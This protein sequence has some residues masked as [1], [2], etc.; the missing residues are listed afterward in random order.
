MGLLAARPTSWV[1]GDDHL[2]GRVDEHAVTVAVTGVTEVG[3]PFWRVDD[4]PVAVVGVL[5]GCVG[6]LLLLTVL[7]GSRDGVCDDGNADH[8]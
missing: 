8:G 1:V 3:K 4:A 2:F 5:D 7:L 6:G